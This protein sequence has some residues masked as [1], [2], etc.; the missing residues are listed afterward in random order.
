MQEGRARQ[1]HERDGVFY[2]M[3]TSAG[4]SRGNYGVQLWLAK[5]RKFYVQVW[6]AVTPRLLFAVCATPDG[7]TGFVCIVGHAPTEASEEVVKDSF[8]EKLWQLTMNLRSKYPSFY[9]YLMVD[10]N[11]RLG[12]VVDDGVGDCERERENSNGSRLRHYLRSFGLCAVNSFFNAGWTWKSSRGPVARIDYVGLAKTLL[13]C[14]EDC[15]VHDQVDLT[16][17]P[18]EDHRLVLMTVVVKQNLMT[19]IEVPA[20]PKNIV[21]KGMLR[22]PVLVD[23]FVAKMWNYTSPYWLSIDDHLEHLNE[24]V[25]KTARQVFGAPYDRPTK[26]WIS[27]PT[28]QVVRMIAPMRRILA[29]IRTLSN[30]SL[31]HA[32]FL[33]WASRIPATFI[34]GNT[35]IR[36]CGWMALITSDEVAWQAQVCRRWEACVHHI[37]STLREI[38]KPLLQA[39][40]QVFLGGM[41]QQAH[42]AALHG[43]SRTTFSIIRRLAGNI[44]RA[45]VSVYQKDGTLTENDPERDLRWTEHFAEV[46]NGTIADMSTLQSVPPRQLHNCSQMVATPENTMRAFAMLKCYKS[47]G[48]DLIPAELLQAGADATAAKYCDLE[49]R[50][51]A[52]ERWPV[53]WKGGRLKDVYKR[54][55][56]PQVC[57]N[58]RG[59]LIADHSGKAFL[60]QVRSHINPHYEKAMPRSQDGAVSKRGTDFAH[61]ILRSFI[62]ISAAMSL[63][64][65]VLF[66]DLARLTV[67]Y[68]NLSWASLQ[69]RRWSHWSISLQWELSDRQLSGL[70]DF[71]M[72]K[73]IFSTNGGLT[74]KYRR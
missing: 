55:G 45:N 18:W 23:E 48:N 49:K 17:Q 41:A 42:T 60:S 67:Q 9:V 69:V 51:V 15:Y 39:D 30:R 70:S 72:R 13:P 63:S 53:R 35:C 16:M 52:E 5:D 36:M 25:R 34:P 56:D 73:D 71:L 24:Y 61:H 1:S 44:G 31:I 65:F 21:N 46:L 43:D 59:V 6:K 58:S 54:K 40:R 8:W 7:Y 47:V 50:V 32:Y 29:S 14:V 57:T 4:D 2:Q 12:S 37:T 22:D 26:Q 62:D 10:A 11:A 64:I 33:M 66:V 28:W 20:K 27:S 68:G 3:L 38:S 19:R 74:A